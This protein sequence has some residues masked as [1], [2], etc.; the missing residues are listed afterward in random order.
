M[1]ELGTVYYIIKR[2]ERLCVENG[3][4]HVHSV[5]VEIGEVSGIIPADIVDCWNWSVKKSTYL[6]R[7]ALR[8]TPPWRTPKP[9]PIAKVNTPIFL[10]AMSTTSR[11]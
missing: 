11:K 2:V 9:A 4:T 6:Q 5:T 1:H 7:T 3:L 8:P 10:R